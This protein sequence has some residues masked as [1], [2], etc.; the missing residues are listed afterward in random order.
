MTSLGF[1]R[2]TLMAFLLAVLGAGAYTILGFAMSGAVAFKVTLILVAAGYGGIVLFKAAETTGRIVVPLAWML[3]SAGSA[4][5]LGLA[6]FALLQIALLWLLR[7]LYLHGGVL[8]ALL[9]LGLTLCA[10]GVAVWAAGTGSIF[11]MV[12]SFL[13][14]QGLALLVPQAAAEAVPNDNGSDDFDRA[15]EQARAALKTLLSR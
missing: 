13:L 14:V 10:A 11:L 7:A 8:A 1:F 2:H 4:P 12:W 15:R 5:V 3:I 6:E 9:D